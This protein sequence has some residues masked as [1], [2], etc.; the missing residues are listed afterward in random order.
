MK[1]APDDGIY[2]APFPG[3]FQAAGQGPTPVQRFFERP[4]RRFLLCQVCSYLKETTGQGGKQPASTESQRQ[5]CPQCHTPLKEQEILDPPAFAPWG[6]T[7]LERQARGHSDRP[8]LEI[9]Y[10]AAHQVMPLTSRDTLA[11]RTK[12]GGVAWEYKENQELLIVNAGPGGTGFT[13]CRSCGAAVIEDSSTSHKHPRPFLS[14]HYQNS[15]CKSHLPYWQGYLGHIMRSDLLLLRLTLPPAT[16]HEVGASWLA[17]AAHTLA[18]ALQLGATRLLDI[19]PGEL[20]IGWNY[21]PA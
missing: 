3:L 12:N 20:R 17:D 19:L 1:A 21:T 8:E 10:M 16:H 11:R 2:V 6:A 13:I 18:Q 7:S 15:F 4:R 5:P 14:H 9:A